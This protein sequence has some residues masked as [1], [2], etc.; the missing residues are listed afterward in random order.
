ML[1]V[2]TAVYGRISD[3]VGL[4]LPLLV[5]VIL[6]A[7]GALAGALA[8]NF[9]VLL[10]ARILQGAGA[11][12]VP[13]IGVAHRD[14]PLHRLRPRRSRWAR[15]PASPRPW[16]PRP[17]GRRR[18]RGP[19]R[20]ACGDR[21]AHARRADLPVA[22]ALDPDQ[23]QRCPSRPVRRGPRGGDRR[24]RGAARAVALDRTGRGRGRRCARRARR[25]RRRRLGPPSSGGLPARR[26]DP[27]PRRR[28]Q[29]PGGRRRPR[30]LV[31]PADRRAGG[32]RRP[33]LGAVAGR[34]GPDP[35]RGDGPARSARRRARCSTGS[36]RPPRSHWPRWSP[37]RSLG[38]SAARAR[39]PGPRSCWWP[40]WSASPSRSGSDSR[41]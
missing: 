31:R 37:R 20:L 34:R 21:A 15:S 36:A 29:R 12:A 35:E 16:L 28:T 24:W 18:D 8:P 22:L 32:A 25:T 41:R 33:R 17:A 39:T 11:A 26:G 23:R 7:V 2:A 30:R 3:L 14:R 10:G 40:R 4:R 13:T 38:V 27:Q 1:A 6:M 19:A 5:G 9:G